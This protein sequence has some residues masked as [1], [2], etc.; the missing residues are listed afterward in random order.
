MKKSYD[1]SKAEKGKF[2]SKD[3][4]FNVPVYLE[5]EILDYFSEKAKSKGVEL[6]ILVNDLLRKDIELIE[7]IN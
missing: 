5:A 1:F 2:F 3:A 6:N 7:N 4:H